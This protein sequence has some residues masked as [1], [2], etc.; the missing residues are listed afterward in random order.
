MSTD[1]LEP[2]VDGRVIRPL[3]EVD[4][5]KDVLAFVKVGAQIRLRDVRGV[6]FHVQHV[7]GDS[8]HAIVLL[9]LRRG[10]R[11]H[12]A[13]VDARL[14][15]KNAVQN[16]RPSLSERGIRVLR[17]AFLKVHPRY[18]GISDRVNAEHR[19]LDFARPACA[20]GRDIGLGIAQGADRAHARHRVKLIR[21]ALARA[22][23][24]VP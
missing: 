16:H 15:G 12:I 1:R 14:R 3:C 20:A 10:E 24:A 17:T 8:H 7:A 9:T 4:L 22:E 21:Q 23:V 5:V 11:H 13:Q 18:L 19:D 2:C 6:D